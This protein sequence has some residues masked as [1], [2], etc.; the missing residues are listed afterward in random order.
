MG[1][2]GG[3]TATSGI[4]YCSSWDL[5][6]CAAGSWS[7]LD[8][9]DDIL[10]FVVDATMHIEQCTATRENQ[11]GTHASSGVVAAVILPSVL[12]LAVVGG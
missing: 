7:V 12:L 5:T 3:D 4:A 1:F 9:N 8:E 2:V 6:D 10:E 11:E